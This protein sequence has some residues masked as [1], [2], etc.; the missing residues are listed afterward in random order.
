MPAIFSRMTVIGM[1]INSQFI[2]LRK[3]VAN[4]DG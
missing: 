3:N 2:E 4:A 1:K